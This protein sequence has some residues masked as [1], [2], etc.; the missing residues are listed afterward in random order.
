[1][2]YTDIYYRTFARLL[3]R[4]TWL[5]TEMIVES[6]IRH[7]EDSDRFL[8][9]PKAQHPIACQLGG[10]DPTFLAEAAEIV[11]RYNYDEINLNC[12]CPSDRVA[13]AGC[14]GAALMLKPELVASCTH[15]MSETVNTPITVKCRLG[16]DD[17]DSYEALSTFVRVVSEESSVQHF[18][19]HARKCLLNGLSPHQNRTVPPLKY[20]WIFALKRDFPD[21][22]FSL[23]GGIL[24]SNEAQDVLN[25]GLESKLQLR[26][27]M[28]GRGAYDNPWKVLSN[29]DTLI[30]G[31][32]FNPCQ[33]RRQALEDYAIAC[34]EIL[35]K[36]RN[37]NR[38]LPSL[39][40]QIKPVL[41]LFHGERRGRKWK[42]LID[43][44]LKTCGNLPQLLERTLPIIP[45]EILDQP[46]PAKEEQNGGVFTT[47]ELPVPVYF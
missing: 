38:R 20:G 11:A 5:Y 46:P 13:G 12:G 35:Q 31:E 6:T 16:V 32:E 29:A 17:V 26:S 28:I 25:H 22:E 45:D 30:F 18:I 47:E 4:R 37:D 43:Q 44:E 40:T 3:S 24:T 2:E 21:L 27:V 23:N 1:M 41:N 8:W 42:A 19:L 34:D 9:F 10:S 36:W 15:K 14:F 39:R 33:N 7:N